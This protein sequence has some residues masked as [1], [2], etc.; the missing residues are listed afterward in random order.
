MNVSANLWARATKSQRQGT[1]SGAECLQSL[2]TGQCL[3][4]L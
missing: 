3:G 2:R 1:K 4:I